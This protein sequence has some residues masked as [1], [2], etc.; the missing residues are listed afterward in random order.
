MNMKK[1]KHWMV[2][3]IVSF[4]I[5]SC[6]DKV[7]EPEQKGNPTIQ[8][9]SAFN[10]VYFGDLLPFEVTVNDNIPLSVLTAILYFGEE[11]VSRTTIRTNENGSYSGNIEVPYGKNIPDGTA[12]LEFILVNT[13]MKKT[14]LSVDVP[15]T[16]AQYPYLILVTDD[17]SYPM[18]PTGEPYEYAATEAFPSSELSAYIKTPII[19]DKGSEIFF[20]WNEGES[21]ITEGI[22][23]NI[24]FVSSTPGSYSVTFNIK[25]FEA[26]PFFELLFNGQKMNMVDKDNYRIDMD[27]IQGEEISMD[28]LTD[29]WVDPDFFLLKDDKLTFIPISGKYRVTANLPFNYLKAEALAGNDY[30]TLQSDG[31]GA[32]WIIGDNVGKPTLENAPGWTPEK[33]I[34]M[35]PIETKK[36]QATFVAG[37]SISIEDINF[38][39]F[40]QRGWGGEF[41]NETLSTASDIVFVGTGDDPGPGN[42]KRDPGNL[43]LYKDKPLTAG[44]TYVFTVDASN[45]INNAVLTVEEK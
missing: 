31:T 32:I 29:W 45:G 44:R 27:L 2:A 35:S 40:H 15:I 28:G 13:T 25:T 38:K 4:A 43:G 6:S 17:T 14:T 9:E 22:K 19:D 20:G 23:T 34:C 39:F 3:F 30:A 10:N 7:E 8:I 41:T 33:G 36:Y 12:L 42:S 16:R 1:I 11:E 24:P 5:L 21:N 26:S 37:T 18:L